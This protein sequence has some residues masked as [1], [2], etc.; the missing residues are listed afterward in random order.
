MNNISS[1]CILCKNKTIYF[2]FFFLIVFGGFYLYKANSGY[3]KEYYK[4]YNAVSEL[5]KNHEI[6]DK[7]L[8]F[9]LLPQDLKFN[10]DFKKESRLTKIGQPIYYDKA[11]FLSG[12]I[13]KEN[14]KISIEQRAGKIFFKIKSKTLVIGGGDDMHKMG[15][16]TLVNKTDDEAIYEY[17]LDQKYK[18][19]NLLFV[20][21][22]AKNKKF[23][24]MNKN[25]NFLAI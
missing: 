2:L 17:E 20:I 25:V 12:E 10:N 3:L 19:D 16:L 22:D 8:F 21:W 1:A 14:D 15:K 9:L 11:T 7:E 18:K 6:K 4:F 5:K 23:L 13:D 24:I